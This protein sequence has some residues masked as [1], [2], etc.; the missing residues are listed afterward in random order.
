MTERE[1]ERAVRDAASRALDTLGKSRTQHLEA[2]PH[3]LAELKSCI[4]CQHLDELVTCFKTCL[5]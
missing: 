3:T 5:G 2:R 1:L 4:T